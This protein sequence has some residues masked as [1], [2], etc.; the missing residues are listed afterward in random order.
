MIKLEGVPKDWKPVRYGKPRL[1]DMVLCSDGLVVRWS[2]T[3][4][5]TSGWYLVV[6]RDEVQ[7]GIR[8]FRN[9]SEFVDEMDSSNWLINVETGALETILLVDDDGVETMRGAV[10]WV[11][12]LS[13]YE[14]ADG[15]VCGHRENQ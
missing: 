10:D 5:Q 14:F 15:R 13:R 9:A 12:L 1:G 11:E 4:E 6:T 2:L 3:E 8:S 7:F